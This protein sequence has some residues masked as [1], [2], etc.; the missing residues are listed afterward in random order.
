MR[1]NKWLLIFFF[2]RHPRPPKKN[3]PL[4]DWSS[5][6]AERCSWLLAKVIWAKLV[7]GLEDQP[8]IPERRALD[9]KARN[10]PAWGEQ[11]PPRRDPLGGGVLPQV[12][13]TPETA[14]SRRPPCTNA[15]DVGSDC[16]HSS[17]AGREACRLPAQA[18]PPGRGD[19]SPPAATAGSSAGADTFALGRVRPGLHAPPWS[20]PLLQPPSARPRPARSHRRPRPT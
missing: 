11:R 14:S 16:T 20:R 2:F 1:E 15:A 9:L 12:P 18:V 5:G 8:W 10:S 13:H 6:D 17:P 19:P 4:P 7:S 3:Q